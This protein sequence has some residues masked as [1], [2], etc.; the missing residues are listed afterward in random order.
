MG[1]LTPKPPLAYAYD[2]DTNKAKIRKRPRRS[3]ETLSLI[4]DVGLF[5]EVLTA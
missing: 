4:T 3:T 1:G 2:R 5:Q